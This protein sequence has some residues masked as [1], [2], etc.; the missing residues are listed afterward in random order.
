M[1]R[2]WVLKCLAIISAAL[3]SGLSHTA[4][5][6]EKLPSARDGIRTE[7]VAVGPLNMP[8]KLPGIAQK[9]H[10]ACISG[11]REQCEKLARAFETGLG[12]LRASTQVATGYLAL[13]CRMKGGWA[14]ARAAEYLAEGWGGRSYDSHGYVLAKSGC[15]ELGDANSCGYQ[16]LGLW[17]GKGADKDKKAA[18]ALWTRNCVEPASESCRFLAGRLHYEGASNAEHAR[19][20]SLYSAACSAQA[21]WG[22]YGL[23]LAHMKGRGADQSDTKAFSI[24][25]KACFEA[26]GD[27]LHPCA[28][29]AEFVIE[30]GQSNEAKA[31]GKILDGACK[32]GRATS[33]SI[34]A[35]AGTSG[36]RGSNLSEGDAPYY[37]RRGCEL[38]LGVACVQLLNMYNPGGHSRLKPNGYFQIALAKRA[39]HLGHVQSCGLI[40]ET[41]MPADFGAANRIDF[42]W[43]IERQLD[44]ARSALEN[45]DAEY[46]ISRV[47][48]LM[49]EG[50]AEANWRLGNLFLTGYPGILDQ[51]GKKA[52][53]LIKNAADYGHA[54]AAVHMGMA[55][56]YG[57]PDVEQDQELAKAYMRVAIGAG[58]EMAEA[59]YRNMLFEPERQRR[60]EA[61]RRQA[62][63]A[64]AN[65]A[66]FDLSRAIATWRPNIGNY[67]S[68]VDTSSSWARYQARADQTNWN[69][70]M[71]YYTGNSSACPSFNQYCR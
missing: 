20:A 56:W 51:S 53:I 33:C 24:T 15:E 26:E 35:L 32:A 41:Q 39:C 70:A 22:C 23:A 62:E 16:G 42:A 27:R 54:E 60:A 7:Y 49:E 50:D 66:R 10:K 45:G 64:A 34:A 3:F 12:D 8:A 37:A 43:P 58:S 38:G 59:I 55:L 11:K 57:E 36:G 5:A 61:A 25:K 46:G 65:A 9:W 47:A 40:E 17:H 31:A 63:R 52:A 4:Y 14:C 28:L 69:N 2:S 13:T 30:L 29:W 6:A 19:A 48:R 71:N 44:A 68:T 67:I 21:A 1:Q 18:I